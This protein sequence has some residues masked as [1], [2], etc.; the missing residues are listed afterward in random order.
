MPGSAMGILLFGAGIPLFDRE[1]LR[2]TPRL[3]INEK[4]VLDTSLGVGFIPWSDIIDA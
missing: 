1:I 4:G 3:I 2:S